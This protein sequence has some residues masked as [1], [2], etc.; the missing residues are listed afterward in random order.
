MDKMLNMISQG[1]SHKKG[2]NQ[3]LA[4]EHRHVI[5]VIP[6]SAHWNHIL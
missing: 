3:T 2:P 5:E 1:Q 6:L 4:I